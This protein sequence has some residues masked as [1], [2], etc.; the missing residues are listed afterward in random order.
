MITQVDVVRVSV[1]HH[2]AQIACHFGV[3]QYRAQKTRLQ[4]WPADF[5][6]V[7]SVEV[8]RKEV[9]AA[10][11]IVISFSTEGHQAAATGTGN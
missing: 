6:N 8:A 7:I 11:L 2:L 3:V 4:R 10:P 9:S 5:C 1:S